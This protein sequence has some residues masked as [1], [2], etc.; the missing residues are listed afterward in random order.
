MLHKSGKAEQELNGALNRM[1]CLGKEEKVGS[2]TSFTSLVSQG[3]ILSADFADDYR[4]SGKL[5]EAEAEI[6][7]EIGDIEYF[8]WEGE[9]SMDDQCSNIIHIMFASWTF[10]GG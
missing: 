1:K 8:F 3:H 6:R 10:E 4:K 7:R 5:K 9:Y 2:R